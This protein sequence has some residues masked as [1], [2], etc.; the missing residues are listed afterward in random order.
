MYVGHPQYDWIAGKKF[1]KLYKDVYEAFIRLLT[2]ANGWLKTLL[3]FCP[4]LVQDFFDK[5][6]KTFL[7]IRAW[8][9]YEYCI[10]FFGLALTHAQCKNLLREYTSLHGSG[11]SVLKPEVLLSFRA[12][13][14][15]ISL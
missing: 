9:I 3:N 5:K 2:D 10:Y 11:K 8:L 12:I 1:G 6:G 7:E 15:D 13:K 4:W 14:A